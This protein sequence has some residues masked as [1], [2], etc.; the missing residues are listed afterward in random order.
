[1]LRTP[2]KKKMLFL[3]GARPLTIHI[4]ENATNI[5][6]TKN[7]DKPW[8]RLMTVPFELAGGS[9]VGRD[10]LLAGKNCHDAFSITQTA[11]VI[12]GAVAD[13]CG[14]GAHSEVGAKLGVRLLPHAIRTALAGD[15]DQPFSWEAVRHSLLDTLVQILC[16]LEGTR[17]TLINDYFLFTLVGV[18]ITPE[19]TTAFALGDGEVIVN[20][21]RT[22]LGP[23]PA[24]DGLGETPPYLAYGLGVSS[25][26]QEE[27]GFHIVR[28]M[29]TAELEHF[30]I[31]TDG[32]TSLIVAETHH[33][34]GTDQ[35]IGPLSQLWT[36]DRFY[37]NPDFGRRFLARANKGPGGYLRDD[38]AFVCGRRIRQED[39]P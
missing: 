29:P 14:S 12:I 28:S 5:L 16:T 18:L 27:F 38:T 9:I 4:E 33:F 35:P 24:A 39:T 2:I 22:M 34:P 1:M 20:G 6:C 30:A 3:I 37:R 23:F 25:L 31:G 15:R 19:I 7:T 17:G 36:D 11:D 8:R 13:G 21:E 32:L 10:H 26:P